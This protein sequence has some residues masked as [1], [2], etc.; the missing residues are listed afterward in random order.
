MKKYLLLLIIAV[1]PASVSSYAQ[2][3]PPES[4]E[5]SVIGWMKVY[6]FKGVKVG[7]KVDDKVYSANQ[8][9]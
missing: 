6:N 7:M 1:V 8:I 4:I 2:S 3:I 5:D 9:S